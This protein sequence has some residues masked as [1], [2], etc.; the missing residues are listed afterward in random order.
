MANSAALTVAHLTI[1]VAL[2]RAREAGRRD[3][4]V[5]NKAIADQPPLLRPFYKERR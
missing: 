3:A 5:E 4:I 1:F 2:S